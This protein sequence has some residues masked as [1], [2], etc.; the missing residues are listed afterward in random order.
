MPAKFTAGAKQ[1]E[2]IF[3]TKKTTFRMKGCF[4]L[5]ITNKNYHTLLNIFA[6]TIIG[7]KYL[8]N[9]KKYDLEI[10]DGVLSKHRVANKKNPYRA[11]RI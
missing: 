2:N 8:N 4:S 5:R 6:T 7:F 11:I 3:Q 9:T 1:I 10:K